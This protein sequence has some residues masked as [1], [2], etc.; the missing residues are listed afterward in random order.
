MGCKIMGT[1]A[2][3]RLSLST[4]LTLRLPTRLHRKDE[5]TN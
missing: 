5:D 4:Y 2:F 3:L 1:C